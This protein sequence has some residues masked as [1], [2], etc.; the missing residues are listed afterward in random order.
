MPS[1]RVLGEICLP[2]S[3]NLGKSRTVARLL[4]LII[5]PT[6]WKGWEAFAKGGGEKI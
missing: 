3:L 2:E 4:A 1:L 6:K 5:V